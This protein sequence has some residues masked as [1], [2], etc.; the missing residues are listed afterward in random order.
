M[1]ANYKKV[2]EFD[3]HLAALEGNDQEGQ[4]ETLESIA[5]DDPQLARQGS[6]HWAIPT[7]R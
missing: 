6:R 4:R 1:K 5:K 3:Q 2:D 7:W